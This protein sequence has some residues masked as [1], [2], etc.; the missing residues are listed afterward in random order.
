[1]FSPPA[2]QAQSKSSGGTTRRLL[3]T[4]VELLGAIGV[5]WARLIAVGDHPPLAV[6][7]MGYLLGQFMQVIP[8]PG[9]VGTIDAGVAGALVLYGA[10]ATSATAAQVIAHA[11]AIL[12]PLIAGG[13][14]FALLPRE[15]DHTRRHTPNAAVAGAAR[16][17]EPARDRL[18]R[19]LKR[20]HVHHDDE[21][22]TQAQAAA[23]ADRESE[24]PS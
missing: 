19:R 2:S 15:I 23:A 10:T 22:A 21:Q 13:I 9:G 7:A 1:M 8:I 24:E 14:A 20:V 12:I 4:W 16:T 3:G 17:V 5:L 6:V 18:A 11:L